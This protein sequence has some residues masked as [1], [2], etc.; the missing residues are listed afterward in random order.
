MGTRNR[1][2]RIIK[3]Y[4]VVIKDDLMAAIDWFWEKKEISGNCNASFLTLIPKNANP[5]G[6]NDFRPI[7]LIG[8]FYKVISKVLAERMKMVMEKLVGKEQ[9]AF[10][11]GRSIRF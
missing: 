4:W 11:K 7:S 9:S 5:L 10:L 6:L 2:G 3:K 1:P 8:I